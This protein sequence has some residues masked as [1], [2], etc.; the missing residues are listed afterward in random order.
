MCPE[1]LGYSEVVCHPCSLYSEVF[2]SQEKSWHLTLRLRVPLASRQAHVQHE[3]C[4][5][6]LP[7]SHTL[8]PICFTG[9]TLTCLN[10]AVNNLVSM[11]GKKKKKANSWQPLHYLKSNISPL[12]HTLALG[13]G[14]DGPWASPRAEPVGALRGLTQPAGSMGGFPV[15]TRVWAGSVQLHLG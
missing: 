11:L 13:T 10:L 14:S 3:C 5:W 1:G 9:E 8:P 15:L 2:L 6:S 4:E 12:H 7:A